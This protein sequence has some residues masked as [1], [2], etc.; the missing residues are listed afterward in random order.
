MKEFLHDIKTSVKN[1]EKHV[2]LIIK[3]QEEEQANFFPRDIMQD[4]IEESEEINQRSSYSSELENFPPSHMEEEEEDAKTKEED[5]PT[6][7]ED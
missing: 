3:P 7:K 1:V 4:P 2:Q 5:A 6:K